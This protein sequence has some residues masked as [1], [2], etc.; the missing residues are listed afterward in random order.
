MY[1]LFHHACDSFFLLHGVVRP[2][3][4][5]HH[6]TICLI[7]HLPDFSTIAYMITQPM[8]GIDDD[9]NAYRGGAAPVVAVETFP[10][11]QHPLEGVQG[12]EALPAPEAL[13]K[14]SRCA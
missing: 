5:A 6:A 8:G 7:F 13:A 12:C 11:G 14:K 10:P 9:P 4:F 3:C 2:W 1:V